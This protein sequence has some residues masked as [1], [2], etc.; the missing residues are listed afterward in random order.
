MKNELL[1][2]KIID[3][4]AN[5]TVSDNLIYLSIAIIKHNNY[6]IDKK[7]TIKIWYK[8]KISF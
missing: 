6:L 1:K 3:S 5:K 4:I 2:N 7:R 8:Y